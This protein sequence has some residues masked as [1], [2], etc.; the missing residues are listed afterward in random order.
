MLDSGALLIRGMVECSGSDSD[1]SGGAVDVVAERVE[2]LHL[3]VRSQP[4]D[5]R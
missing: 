4:R 3:G 2:R 5:F 1:G